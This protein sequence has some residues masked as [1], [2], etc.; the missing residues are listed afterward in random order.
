M[1]ARRL[2]RRALSVAFAALLTP[3]FH[4]L[5]LRACDPPLTRTMADAIGASW[6]QTGTLRWVE[7]EPVDLEAL[8]ELPRM[9]LTAEDDAFFYHPGV[10]VGGLCVALRRNADSGRVVAGGSTITQ[11][12]AK[13][14]F[15]W[16][17]RSYVRKGLELYYALWMELLLPKERIL[18]LYLS[19]AELG[20][21]VFGAEA[22]A[23][24]WY[25]KPAVA[26]TREEAARI[27]S[28][29]PSPRTRDPR[30]RES[31]RR[32]R[33]LLARAAVFPGE[34]GYEEV[35]EAWRERR[36]EQCVE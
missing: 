28:I 33:R 21:L 26:L 31:G 8:G 2:L 19:V 23:Q 20:P 15:L 22:A 13:N 35:G 18:E 30:S 25:G 5:C 10:D 9:A 36:W 32:A 4:V 3:A 16:Q 11:Q 1:S 14:V 6:E 24:H 12:T 7:R 34:E 29:L 27:A 17:E